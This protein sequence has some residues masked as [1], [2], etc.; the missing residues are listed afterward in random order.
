MLKEHYRAVSNFRRLIDIMLV[1]VSFYF[2]HIVC[3][4]FSFK[5]LEEYTRTGKVFLFLIMS[6]IW[7]IVLKQNSLYKSHRFET[8]FMQLVRIVKAVSVAAV[9]FL[10]AI[11]IFE[12]P[13]IG[14]IFMTIFVVLS[15]GSLFMENV[16]I[17]KLAESLRKLN[18]NTRNVIVVGMG[19]E[20]ADILLKIKENPGW[21]LKLVGII[22][23]DQIDSD[24][25]VDSISAL[26]RLHGY[27]ILGKLSDFY[28]ITKGNV[29][30][31]VFFSGSP[32]YLNAM[33]P[34][35]QYCI[36]RGIDTELC[37]T[38]FDKLDFVK[39]FVDEIGNLPLISFETA[40]KK[41]YQL[42]VKELID[43]G[44]AFLGLFILAPLFFITSL[45]IRLDS[46]G[47]VF[48]KQKRV[49]RHGRIFEMYKFR[50]MVTD[51]E[52]RKKDLFA[53]NEMSGPVF[54]ITHDPRITRVGKFIRK[55]SLDELPQLINVL[56]GEMSL[57]GPRPPLPSEVAQYSD[58]QIRRLS[59]KPG[60]TCT[61][62]V[63]GR[64]HIDF[65]TWIKM[66]L[67]YIDKWSLSKDAKLLLKTM[68]AILFQN[69][70]K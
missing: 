59:V 50:S 52:A 65:E 31:V 44:I 67:D 64:N 3:L 22:I 34:Y 54:K 32:W 16:I 4:V 39:M 1:H 40:H 8:L 47:S 58:C 26:S 69:G 57:V 48:F 42:L 36:Q 37:A 55:T 13:A 43:R 12:F 19:K 49:G 46:P 51:A 7:W 9:L 35:I 30:D 28:S 2:T 15:L 18:I 68:P 5:S 24:N 25:N 14:K 62:Q 66:D 38:F 11:T 17:A 27:K 21:G 6:V 63:S 56:R 23:P 53:L 33:Q 20:A 41:P 10:A 61:W 29:I 60:I 45:A 70:A